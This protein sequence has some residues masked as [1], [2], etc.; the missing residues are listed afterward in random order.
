MPFAFGQRNRLIQCGV[1]GEVGGLGG[2]VDLVEAAAEIGCDL[3]ALF[4]LIVCHHQAAYAEFRYVG[5]G[6]AVP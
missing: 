1:E 4:F 6:E 3:V 5:P 2:V